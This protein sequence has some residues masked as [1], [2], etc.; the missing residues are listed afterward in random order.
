MD[1]I[2]ILETPRDALQ[3][4]K[5]FIP[6]RTKAD[7]INS[8]LRVGFDIV[9]F[10]SFVSPK[11]IPQL[12]DTAEV[13]AK[14]DLEHTNTKLLAIVGNERG[15]KTGAAFEQIS[16]LGYP[17]SISEQFLKLNINSTLR[18]SRRRA[19][20]I[21][22]VCEEGGKKLIIYLSMA[23]GNKYGDAW[24]MDLLMEECD[25]LHEMGIRNITLSDTI[26]IA[27]PASVAASF[28]HLTPR[29]PDVEFGLH[30]H[31]D[32]TQWYEKLHAAY[33]HGCRLFDGVINGLGG[34][35]MAGHK[36]VGNL[37]T[38]HI[39]EYIDRNNLEIKIDKEAFENA[40]TKAINTFSL[41][42]FN[43]NSNFLK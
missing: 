37:R 31:T 27:D 38:G 3:G 43:N 42:D 21:Q 34:C 6:T 20:A 36:L 4:I 41:I 11:A 35:P 32:L 2:K 28:L 15:A 10:G 22:E 1:R 26:G 24:S 39:L 40:L 8:L 19:E 13:L 9:D 5:P 33:I 30:L 16:F 14:L 25:M 7:Y 18:K 23:Y 29:F 17:H 12:S